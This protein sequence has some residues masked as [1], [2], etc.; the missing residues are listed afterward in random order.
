MEPVCRIAL[1]AGHRDWGSVLIS[2]RERNP[3]VGRWWIGIVLPP[4]ALFLIFSVSVVRYRSPGFCVDK[5]HHGL[6]IR[7]LYETRTPFRRGDL[8]VRIDD[9]GYD[10]ILSWLLTGKGRATGPYRVTLIRDGHEMTITPEM[11]LVLP[12]QLIS[13]VWPQ[14]VLVFLL[15]FLGALAFLRTPGNQPSF[16][17]LLS[18]CAFATTFSATIPSLFGILEPSV[19]SLSFATLAVS[20]WIAFGAYLHFVFKFPVGRDLIRGR[21]WMAVLF[22]AVSPLVAVAGAAAFSGG[23]GDFWGWL[24]RLRNVAL[25]VMTLAAFSKHFIDYRRVASTPERNQ[26]RLILNAYWLSFGPYFLLYAIPNIVFGHPVISFKVVVLSG[27]ILPGAYFIALVR[28]RLL[29]V[30]KMISRTVAY[31]LLIGLLYISYP[32]L[33]VTLKRRFFGMAYFSEEIFLVYVIG[34][35]IF[36]EPVLKG[37][38]YTLDRVFQPTVLYRY[39]MLPALSRGIGASIFPGDLTAILTRDIPSVFHLTG[40]CLV[41][42]DSDTVRTFPDHSRMA[43]F[44]RPDGPIRKFFSGAAGYLF[45]KDSADETP[46]EHDLSV[47]AMEGFELIFALRGGEGTS[48]LLLFGGRRDRRPF[49]RRDIDIFATIAN[50]AGVTLENTIR[51]ES[52]MESKQQ[53]EQLFAKVIQSEKMATLGEMSTVLAHELK[54]PLGIIRSSAQHLK[55]PDMNPGH[56]HELLDFIIDEVDDLSTFIN[57]ILGLARYKKP[58]FSPV[59]LKKAMPGM[60]A[61]WRASGNHNK[62]VEIRLALENEIPRIY[63]DLK[64]LQQVFLNCITNAE[65]AMPF[66]GHVDISVR[67]NDQH[68]VRV[69]IMDDGP[70][71]SR[72]NLD[73]VFKKF[74]TTKEK[75]IGIGLPVSRQIVH[76][77][78]GHIDVDNRETGGVRVTITLLRNPL[79]TPRTA[80]GPKGAV[81]PGK[82]DSF[83]KDTDHRR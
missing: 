30:D 50:H 8:I 78:N 37:I 13:T 10:T 44:F 65:D 64:Q 81:A 57:K 74:F 42:I 58:I 70:G 26:V 17:F 25:P 28:Y 36:F 6:R 18:V 79:A 27:I 48:G 7:R 51:Y 19:I 22:Y 40:A 20:N 32:Y 34:V 56:L 76:A 31:F 3:S 38:S 43:S 21:S 54:N 73:N 59:N 47:I 52:L 41:R 24:E 72:E 62:A 66:G 29:D 67:S 53:A 16:L 80:D 14:A 61:R 68:A 71:I 12:F 33:V 82:E 4:I 23:T 9:V 5:T 49:T 55:S 69:Q 63:A 35:A 2:G 46:L 11:H 60:I 83:E 39:D 45:T 75:G 77:H 1:S 15:L